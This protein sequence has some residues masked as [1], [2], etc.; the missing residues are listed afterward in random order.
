MFKLYKM[1]SNVK[2]EE[3]NEID[4]LENSLKQIIINKR[5]LNRVQH[6]KYFKLDLRK[7]RKK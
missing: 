7:N 6:F 2:N 1:H 3:K 5:R 4:F